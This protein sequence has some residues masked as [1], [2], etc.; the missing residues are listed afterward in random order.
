MTTAHPRAAVSGHLY[1]TDRDL[2]RPFEPRCSAPRSLHHKYG[3]G[4]QL[5]S[6]CFPRGSAHRI[7]C[8]A[9]VWGVRHPETWSL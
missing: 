4:R 8:A 1:R 7:S 5:R 9:C 2:S 3:D 6:G